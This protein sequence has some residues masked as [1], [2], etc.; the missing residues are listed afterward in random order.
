[1]LAGRRPFGVN[2]ELVNGPWRRF[3]P[4]PAEGWHEPMHWS[5]AQRILGRLRPLAMKHDG[6]PWQPWE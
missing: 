6:T 4:P 5:P 2:V 3:I 1:M